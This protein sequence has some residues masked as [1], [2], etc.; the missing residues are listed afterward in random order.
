MMVSNRNRVYF[1][2]RT[3]SFREGKMLQFNSSFQVLE[4]VQ[5][6]TKCILR[7]S[8]VNS[9]RIGTKVMF[10]RGSGHILLLTFHVR[11]S[12]TYPR[13][14]TC[15]LRSWS[16]HVP[17]QSSDGCRGGAC[18]THVIINIMYFYEGILS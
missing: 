7:T 6:R 2:G 17:A 16:C 11:L 4:K 18:G 12:Q 5:L 15:I 1:Q 8:A 9:D 14:A 10:A 13:A 3:V